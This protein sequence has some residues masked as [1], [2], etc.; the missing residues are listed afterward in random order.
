MLHLPWLPYL[1][2]K[3]EMGGDTSRSS[4]KETSGA[5]QQI[6]VCDLR[7]LLKNLP[8]WLTYEISMIGIPL[9]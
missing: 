5:G 7:V 8:L 9:C 4:H 2:N 3:V 1:K 6:L